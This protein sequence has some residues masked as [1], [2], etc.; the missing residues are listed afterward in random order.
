[1]AALAGASPK[2][3]DE[4]HRQELRFRSVAF[5]LKLHYRMT[6]WKI[7]ETKCDLTGHDGYIQG[8][9]GG[10]TQGGYEN[11]AAYDGHHAVH[12]EKFFKVDAAW[13]SID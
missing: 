1:M 5:E 4:P 13:T 3:V 9:P 7:Y 8:T 6:W 12:V 11:H 2:L 10:Y